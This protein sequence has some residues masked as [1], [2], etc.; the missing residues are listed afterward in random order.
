M[1][2]KQEST[3]TNTWVAL[4]IVIASAALSYWLLDSRDDVNGGAA[5][6]LFSLGL[7]S[8]LVI[9]YSRS[10]SQINALG[11]QVKFNRLSQEADA[12]R[13]SLERDRLHLYRML[14]PLTLKHPEGEHAIHGVD[15]RVPALLELDDKITSEGLQSDLSPE[16]TRALHRLLHSQYHRIMELLPQDASMPASQR[17]SSQG[18]DVTPAQL[19]E[20]LDRAE[21]SLERQGETSTSHDGRQRLHN[22][23]RVS[24]R[25]LA[26]YHRLDDVTPKAPSD[27]TV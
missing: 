14:I 19:G 17:T 9:G 27:A 4:V 12:T 15:P 24:R 6:S 21:A 20:L 10:V 16:L 13:K 26:S 18:H 3:R 22:N 8:A 25:L 11:A 7:V 5:V 2:S 23:I 1:H